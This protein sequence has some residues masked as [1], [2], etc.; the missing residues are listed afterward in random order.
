MLKCVL[1][2]IDPSGCISK[3]TCFDDVWGTHRW[4]HVDHVE[5]NS[6][7]FMGIQMLEDGFLGFRLDLDQVV[8]QSNIDIFSGSDFFKC[9]AVF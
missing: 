9:L 3:R 8:L 4:S 7:L 6:Y 1:V 2:N 5:G